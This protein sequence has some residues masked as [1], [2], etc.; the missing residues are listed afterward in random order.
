MPVDEILIHPAPG[1][2]WVAFLADGHVVELWAEPSDRPSGVGGIALAR[3]TGK[4]PGLDALTVR[5]PDGE[6]FV[7]D[8]PKVDDGA[9]LIVQ[10]T[11]DAI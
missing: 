5:L 11:R 7:K 8:A 1:V 10:I 2:T 6:A 3:V 4:R 9:A